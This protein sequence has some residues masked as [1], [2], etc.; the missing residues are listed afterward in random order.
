[1]DMSAYYRGRLDAHQ[2]D[3]ENVPFASVGGLSARAELIPPDHITDVDVKEYLY[4]YASGARELY[5][6]DWRTCE[7]G[8]TEALAVKRR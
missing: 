3:C 1:M 5:G 2:D 4:G 6:A 7:F 8:W